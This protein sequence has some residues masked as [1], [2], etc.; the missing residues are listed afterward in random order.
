MAQMPSEIVRRFY[1]SQEF[2]SL[3]SQLGLKHPEEADALAIAIAK[4][5]DGTM[6]D[7]IRIF[8]IKDY[9]MHFFAAMTLDPK[10]IKKY[11]DKPS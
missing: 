8:L 10:K 2:A 4:Q 5:F 6:S 9:L 7:E 3:F 1:E 11:A